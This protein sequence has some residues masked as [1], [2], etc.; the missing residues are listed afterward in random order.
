M[1]FANIFDYTLWAY[2][3]EF[4]GGLLI[5]PHSFEDLMVYC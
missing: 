5:Y 3:I 2:L 1:L 4:G